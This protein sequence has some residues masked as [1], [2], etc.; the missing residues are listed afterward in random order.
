MVMVYQ[1][2]AKKQYM[3]MKKMQQRTS[4]IIA[5]LYLKV[6]MRP[7]TFLKPYLA[8]KNIFKKEKNIKKI[9]IYI[10]TGVLRA[11]KLI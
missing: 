4:A 3:P 1:S 8:K 10:K 2:M 9:L 7:S 5:V 11:L 6:I